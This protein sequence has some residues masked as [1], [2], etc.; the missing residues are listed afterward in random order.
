MLQR[1]AP[2]TAEPRCVFPEPHSYQDVPLSRKV[3]LALKHASS[4]SAA[5]AMIHQMIEALRK[6]LAALRLGTAVTGA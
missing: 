6:P 5:L 4:E 3:L 2:R 1:Q